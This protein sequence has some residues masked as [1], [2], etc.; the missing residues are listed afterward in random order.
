M[1]TLPVTAGSGKHRNHFARGR[2]DPAQCS[3]NTTAQVTDHHG[4]PEDEWDL[5]TEIPLD[6]YLA[7]MTVEIAVESLKSEALALDAWLKRAAV[8]CDDTQWMKDAVEAAHRPSA[9]QMRGVSALTESELLP[10]LTL[11]SET[12]ARHVPDHEARAFK[13]LLLSLAEQ[14]AGASEG[15]F[16][17]SPRLSKREGDL[18]WKMRQALGLATQ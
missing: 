7:I 4:F 2:V 5:I 12:L 3:P 10:K 13:R 17:G 9:A 6:I 16:P 1:T 8:A 15:V 14:V 11:L 18:I